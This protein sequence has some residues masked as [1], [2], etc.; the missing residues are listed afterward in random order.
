[1]SSAHRFERVIGVDFSGAATPGKLIWIASCDLLPDAS[2]RLTSLHSLDEL[3][4]ATE[5]DACLRWLVDH[6]AG[7]GRALWGMDFPFS[8]PVEI[9]GDE[10]DQLKWVSGFEGN[11]Y[12]FGRV[13]VS[14][15]MN[16]GEKLHLRRDTDIET[17]TPFDCYHYRIVC[18]T[19]HGMRDVLLP[20]RSRCGVAV[21]PLEMRKAARADTIVVEACPGST[22]KRMKL[23]HNRYKDPTSRE[24][25]KSKRRVREVIL[26]GLA[27]DVEI[28]RKWRAVALA[29]P[30]GDALDAIIAAVGSWNAWRAAD[31][32]AIARHPRYPREGLVFA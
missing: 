11:A 21:V 30:G 12:D 32:N 27:S 10:R 31:L 19:F 24:V 28:D 16:L 4:G 23:P 9:A 17:K 25:A 18:Q 20:L 15:A 7:S 13:C 26:S 14:R 8:L 5:R 6:I 3:S 22:L 2:M 29:Q 1:M